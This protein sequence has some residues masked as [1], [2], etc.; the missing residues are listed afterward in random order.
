MDWLLVFVCTNRSACVG[1][2][3]DGWVVVLWCGGVVV[4]W[5][6]SHFLEA[7]CTLSF[8]M[9]QHDYEVQMQVILDFEIP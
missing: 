9:G 6:S 2:G 3:G 7:I 5:G 4:C 1:G 8:F